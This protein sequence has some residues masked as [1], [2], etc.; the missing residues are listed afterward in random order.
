M[1]GIRVTQGRKL[2]APLGRVTVI[3]SHTPS[4]DLKL[5]F[6]PFFRGNKGCWK[7]CNKTSDTE[8]PSSLHDG[9]GREKTPQHRGLSGSQ[10]HTQDMK[11]RSLR[12]KSLQTPRLPAGTY[13]CT[14]TNPLCA[15]PTNPSPGVPLPAQGPGN[16][17]KTSRVASRQQ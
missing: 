3:S 13:P 12:C 14:H 8:Q 5:F 10:P 4:S 9:S 2:L 16:V 11:P 7:P 15:V 17:Q 6:L 1:K